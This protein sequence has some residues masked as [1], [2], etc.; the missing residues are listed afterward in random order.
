MATNAQGKR[1]FIQI[2]R[3]M[4]TFD[5]ALVADAV[6]RAI[7]LGTI[8]FDAVKQLVVAYVERRP[9]N[10]DLAAYPHLAR[11]QVRATRAADYNA[12]TGGMAA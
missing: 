11:T 6:D 3:L 2:L 12:L 1:A 8:S 7:K 10:L 5:E 4:E 9:E